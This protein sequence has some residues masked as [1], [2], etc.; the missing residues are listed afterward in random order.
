MRHEFHVGDNVMAKIADSYLAKYLGYSEMPGEI[1][2]VRS[3]F[4]KVELWDTGSQDSE[5]FNCVIRC[6]LSHVRALEGGD[7]PVPYYEASQPAQDNQEAAEQAKAECACKPKAYECTPKANKHAE[8]A[9]EKANCEYYTLREQG[10]AQAGS[11]Y[12]L[13]FMAGVQ[14]QKAEDAKENAR[15][16]TEG[17]IAK[18]KYEAACELWL[19]TNKKVSEQACEIAALKQEVE[20][21]NEMVSAYLIVEKPL[22]ESRIAKAEE[23]LRLIKQEEA[24]AGSGTTEDIVDRYFAAFPSNEVKK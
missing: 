9:A 3:T 2:A 24:M 17:A 11:P 13:G 19:R 5:G 4:F 15:I 1:I 23:A 8:E 12:Y 16:I 22:L 14:W 20:R 10:K 18:G 21:L 7:K 6:D